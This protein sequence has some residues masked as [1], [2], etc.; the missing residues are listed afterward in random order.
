[1]SE[2]DPE[3]VELDPDEL[4]ETEPLD[5][6]LDL[7]APE[8][9]AAEQHAPVVE[10]GQQPLVRVPDEANPADVVEQGQSVGLDEDDYR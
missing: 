5:G 10:D 2:A 6:E 8:A 1:M 7:E 3:I 4:A 9:D